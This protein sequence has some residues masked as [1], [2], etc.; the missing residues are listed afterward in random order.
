MN[1]RHTQKNGV[2]HRSDY[3]EGIGAKSVKSVKSVRADQT[4]WYAEME[5]QAEERREPF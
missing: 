2:G 5:A 1:G 3:L 4:D